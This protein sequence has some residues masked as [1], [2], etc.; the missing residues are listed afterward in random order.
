MGQW[1]QLK[2]QAAERQSTQ[3]QL[4][5][6]PADQG[7][8]GS[9]PHHGDLTVNHQD[10]KAVGDAAYTLYQDFDHFSDLAR[11]SS[12]TAAGGLSDQGF[13]IGSALDH[14]AERWVDQVQSLLDACVHIYSHLDFTNSVHTNDDTRVYSTISSISTLDKGFD[15]HRGY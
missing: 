5:Q 4:N 15:D 10:L 12:M 1:E 11:I 9:T 14:V 3:M 2:A 6:L 8:G 13:V 7:G